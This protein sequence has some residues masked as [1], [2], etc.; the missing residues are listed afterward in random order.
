MPDVFLQDPDE[1][2]DYERDWST[3]LGADTIAT[4]TWTPD[5]GITV[6][7]DSHDTT[8]ATVWISG[9]TDGTNYDVL[10]TVTTAGGRTLEHSLQFRIRAK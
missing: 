7:S 1:T 3:E 4:S 5:T 2:K 9:G 10:N 6:D 8:T